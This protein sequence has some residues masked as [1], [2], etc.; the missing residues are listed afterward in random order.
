M[1]YY[2]PKSL[3]D[4]EVYALSAYILFSNGLVNESFEAN[5]STLPMIRMPALVR[6]QILWKDEEAVSK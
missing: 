3:G 5:R 1:P 2:A 6:A 4:N